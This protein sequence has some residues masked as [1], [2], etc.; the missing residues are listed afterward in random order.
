MRRLGKLSHSVKSPDLEKSIGR[1]YNRGPASS[2][3][4]RY[5]FMS[6]Q[7]QIEDKLSRAFPRGYREVLNESHMHSVPPNSLVVYE[8]KQ[9]SILSKS[10]RR[11]ADSQAKK[12][13]KA[14]KKAE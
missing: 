6:V 8:E 7:Q 4:L 12:T 10:A 11:K 9:L 3:F 5:S 13:A 2:V 14:K 1:A